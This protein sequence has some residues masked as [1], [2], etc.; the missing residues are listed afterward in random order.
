MKSRFFCL[1]VIAVTLLAPA[2]VVAQIQLRVVYHPNRDNKLA[3]WV[4]QD[5]GFFKKNGLDVTLTGESGLG[6]NTVK[7]VLSKQIDIGVMGFRDAVRPIIDAKE[8]EVAFIAS[9][10][11]NPFNFLAHSDIKSPQDLKGKKIWTA[12]F[13]RGPDVATR[14]VLRHLGIDPEKDVQLITCGECTGSLVDNPVVGVKWIFDGKVSASLANRG[15]LK[16]IEKEGKKVTVLADFIDSGL[17]ITAADVIVR[18]DWLKANRESAKSFLR[19]LIEATA[20]AKKNKDASDAILKKY[21]LKEFA[22]GMETKFED[23]VLGVLPQKP[24]PSAKGLEIAIQEKAPGHD[25]F[26]NKK[27]SDFIDASLMSEIEKEGLFDQLYR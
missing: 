11:A 13:G 8:T 22:T 10:A 7:A 14:V 1:L 6:E 24:Y 16:D 4:A 25:F 20:Y 12:Q 3:L 26:Q 9:L 2:G 23:Y 18:S 15:T 17:Y 27:A 19:A 21:L 5:A